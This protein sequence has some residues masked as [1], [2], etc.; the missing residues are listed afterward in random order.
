MVDDSEKGSR[1]TEDDATVRAR[2]LTIGLK[3]VLPFSIG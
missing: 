3:S 2:D 1:V